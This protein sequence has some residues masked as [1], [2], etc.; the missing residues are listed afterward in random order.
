MKAFALVAIQDDKANI[1]L[2]QIILYLG[3]DFKVLR[4]KDYNLNNFTKYLLQGL[5]NTMQNVSSL[6]IN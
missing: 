5:V 3:F 6:W 2:H 4:A 1:F